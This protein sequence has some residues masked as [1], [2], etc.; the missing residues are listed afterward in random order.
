VL[1]KEGINDALALINPGKA[2]KQADFSALKWLQERIPWAAAI[3]SAETAK[4]LTDELTAGYQLGES[5]DDISRRV[6]KLFDGMETYRAQRIARTEIIATSNQAAL[7]TYQDYG[8]RKK[9]WLA[10]YDERTRDSHLIANGQVVGI[11][12]NFKVGAG[13]GPAPGQIGLPE[14]DINCRCTLLPGIE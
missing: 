2:L 1:A 3:I 14:E 6:K 7:S 11:N 9:E 8:V 5:I 12:E 10:A 4:L 13:S